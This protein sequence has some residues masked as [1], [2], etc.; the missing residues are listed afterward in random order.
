MLQ[1]LLEKVPVEIERK[2]QVKRIIGHAHHTVSRVSCLLGK[3]E[4]EK[5]CR[6]TSKILANVSYRKRKPPTPRHAGRCPP[7]REAHKRGWG[8]VGRSVWAPQEGKS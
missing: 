3:V 2:P 7:Q 4:K 6:E 8:Q 5:S 1:V